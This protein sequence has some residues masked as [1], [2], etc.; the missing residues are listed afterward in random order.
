M[1]KVHHL[2]SRAP[3]RVSSTPALGDPPIAAQAFGTVSMCVCVCVYGERD[4]ERERVIYIYIYSLNTRAP[5]RPSC[6][7]APGK[8]ASRG[9]SAR[10]G[11]HEGGAHAALRGNPLLP[12]HA[13]T[14]ARAAAREEL[15]GLN[16]RRLRKAG[17]G[18]WRPRARSV[19]RL[20]W[21]AAVP[22]AAPAPLPRAAP[23]PLPGAAP[24]LLPRAARP[25]PAGLES[26]LRATQHGGWRRR[27]SDLRALDPSCLPH[28]SP[29]ARRGTA[30][31]AA[32]PFG[33][34]S[35]P[36]AGADAACAPRAGGVPHGAPATFLLS[37]RR[38]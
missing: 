3:H 30:A 7:R 28:A 17:R 6:A 33:H 2:D 13:A 21:S 32:F 12:A 11:Q 9:T 35:I 23:V 20:S 38:N 8:P 4:G 5:H 27:L 37:R 10:C 29:A 36:R 34:C 15:H 19:Q 25:A 22:R 26:A 16:P 31:A 1:Y 18:G 14:T 24:A